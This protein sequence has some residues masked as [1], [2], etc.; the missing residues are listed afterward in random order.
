MPCA[1]CG[2]TAVTNSVSS[3]QRL[4]R[5]LHLAGEVP[6][7]L[8]PSF[9]GPATSWGCT[10]ESLRGRAAALGSLGPRSPSSSPCQ[11]WGNWGRVCPGA[12]EDHWSPSTLRPCRSSISQWGCQLAL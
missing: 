8:F 10:W 7:S 6:P 2:S 12:Q 9:V 4:L 3:F 1:F 11:L 5:A